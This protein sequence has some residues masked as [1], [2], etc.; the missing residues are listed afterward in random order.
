VRRVFEE[1]RIGQPKYELMTA[2]F[3]DATR[4]QLTH[5]QATVTQLGAVQAVTFKG[6][7]PGGAD[8]YEVKSEHG[9][10][11]CRISLDSDGK[12]SGMGFPRIRNKISERRESGIARQAG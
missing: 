7:G 5:L 3:A 10:I 1:L 6:V 12:V 8:I 9:S 4:Q 2:A 11:E